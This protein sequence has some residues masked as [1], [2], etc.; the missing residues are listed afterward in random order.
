MN[1]RNPNKK[2]T[3]LPT[4]LHS[5]S[6]LINFIDSRSTNEE[7]PKKSDVH[8]EKQN[9]GQNAFFFFFPSL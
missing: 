9:A 6:M 2:S 7:L 8:I 1:T 3:F 4:D 5:S